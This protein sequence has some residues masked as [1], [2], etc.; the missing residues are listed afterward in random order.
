M[1]SLFDEYRDGYGQARRLGVPWTG[2]LAGKGER[3]L[4]ALPLGAQYAC[5]AR[6]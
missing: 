5:S 1:A 4:A 6:A 3:A 2:A